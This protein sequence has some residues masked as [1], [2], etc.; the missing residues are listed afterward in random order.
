[1]V[2]SLQASGPL[3]L[4]LLPSAPLADGLSSHLIGSPTSLKRTG[5]SKK[6][7]SA[8]FFDIKAP[9]LLALQKIWPVCALHFPRP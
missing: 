7:N 3:Y 9:G 6:V 8:Q 4:T 1:M 2:H 5:L